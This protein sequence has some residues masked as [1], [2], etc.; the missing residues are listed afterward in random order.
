ME[1][2]PWVEEK[3]VREEGT[4]KAGTGF[5]YDTSSKSYLPLTSHALSPLPTN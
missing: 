4:A 2:C 5:G 3:N 1:G